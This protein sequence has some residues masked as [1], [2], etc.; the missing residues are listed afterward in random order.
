MSSGETRAKLKAIE[1]KMQSLILD[2]AAVVSAHDEAI[3]ELLEGYPN[4]PAYAEE[5]KFEW[6]EDEPEFDDLSDRV[7]ECFKAVDDVTTKG[8]RFEAK[9]AKRG[10]HEN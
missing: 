9:A 4:P 3:E 6:R 10:R 2:A 1:A 7:K 5:A 8:E